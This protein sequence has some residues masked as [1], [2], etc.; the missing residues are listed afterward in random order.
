MSAEII[1]SAIVSLVGAFGG[2]SLLFW[3]QEK[4]AK[5]I[6]NEASAAQTWRELFERT[7]KEREER[8]E[9]IEALYKE[10]A[11]LKDKNAALKAE[12]M[13]LQWFRC[14]RNDCADRQPPRMFSEVATT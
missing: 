9:K 8:D 3:R 14:T 13:R 5:E 7:D 4:R 12:N 10:R 6:Q 1:I 11:E 2:A